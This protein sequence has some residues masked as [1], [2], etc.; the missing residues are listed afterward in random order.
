MEAELKKKDQE[1]QECTFKPKIIRKESPQK[2]STDKT[3]FEKL[4]LVA[5]ERNRKIR[6]AYI[7]QK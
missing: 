1:L 4:N 2:E 6:E 5:E 7:E 3:V